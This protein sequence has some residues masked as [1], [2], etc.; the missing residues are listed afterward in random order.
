MVENPIP[1][2]VA[3]TGSI[4]ENS[5]RFLYVLERINTLL[6]DNETIRLLAL[7]YENEAVLQSKI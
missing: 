2:L 1:K 5:A 4:A 7:Y 6:K 3:R